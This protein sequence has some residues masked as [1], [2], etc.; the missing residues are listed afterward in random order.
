MSEIL[1]A[2]GNEL[3]R[4]IARKD[5]LEI[6]LAAINAEIKRLQT[7]VVPDELLTR[8]VKATTLENGVKLELDRKFS[9]GISYERGPEA[10]RIL[11]ANGYAFDW[12]ASVKLPSAVYA[13]AVP[14]MNAVL[15]EFGLSELKIKPDIH[16]STFR[17]ICKELDQKGV[18]DTETQ[19]TLG[20][21]LEVT[22]TV[23]LPE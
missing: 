20:T 3:A 10:A 15:Q 5:D 23:K 4:L 19:Q 12:S 11:T 2:A 17:K 6:E 8:G 14:K 9:G 16:H 18:L 21:V 22:S 13:D 1:N 7:Q